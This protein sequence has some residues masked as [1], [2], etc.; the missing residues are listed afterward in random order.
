MRFIFRIS[1]KEELTLGDGDNGFS[2]RN[3][4]YKYRSK[5]ELYST[6]VLILSTIRSSITKEKAIIILFTLIPIN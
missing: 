6:L 4:E 2:I 3:Q 1:R 5:K